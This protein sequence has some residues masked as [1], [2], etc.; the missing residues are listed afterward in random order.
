MATR[1]CG[2]PASWPR[3]DCPRRAHIVTWLAVFDH[4]FLAVEFGCYK[5]GGG[6]GTRCVDIV[7][8]YG[9]SVRQNLRVAIGR[10]ITV[11]AI[12]APPQ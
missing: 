7:R 5:A 12:H 3:E 11:P 4:P 6:V 10:P 8:N 9:F 2:C 1:L